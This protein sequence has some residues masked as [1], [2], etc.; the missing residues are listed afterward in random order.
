MGWERMSP[1][2]VLQLTVAADNMQEAPVR[3]VER[4]RKFLL[5]ECFL[6]VAKLYSSL[7]YSFLLWGLQAFG[8]T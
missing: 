2:G 8:H 5:V 3:A 7:A 6:N 1:C 4:A